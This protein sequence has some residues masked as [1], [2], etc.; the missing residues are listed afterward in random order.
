MSLCFLKS[1][2]HS[3][4]LYFIVSLDP[5]QIVPIV[6]VVSF[7]DRQEKKSRS[8]LSLSCL[9]SLPSLHV[10]QSFCPSLGFK[11]QHLQSTEVGIVHRVW[12]VLEVEHGLWHHHIRGLVGSVWTPWA[13]VVS[14]RS[15][16]VPGI[17]LATC[18]CCSVYLIYSPC[19]ILSRFLCVQFY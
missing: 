8:G 10:E 2:S 6:P 14:A 19:S 7:T 18:K 13:I 3:T 5:K 9:P 17:V 4:Y 1:E 12:L 16:A 11:H 15:S